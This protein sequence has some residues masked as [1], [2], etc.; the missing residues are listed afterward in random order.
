MEYSKVRR[1]SIREESV[2]TATTSSR[3]KNRWGSSSSLAPVAST[4]PDWVSSASSRFSKAT[5]SLYQ[6]SRGAL[7]VLRSSSL[8]DLRGSSSDLRA[9]NSDLRASNSNLRG[10]VS[11]L[12]GSTSNLHRASSISNLHSSKL[13]ASSNPMRSSVSDLR[14]STSELR[15]STADLR[16]STSCLAHARDR[17]R[18]Q[19]TQVC[20]SR[21]YDTY[22]TTPMLC[23]V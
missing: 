3:S 11:D 7:G 10:S 17:A 12:R 14:S 16:G 19:T 23:S 1:P 22:R 13:E 8:F 20:T 18:R 21:I 4:L 9:S 2:P 15:S 5:A 6:K